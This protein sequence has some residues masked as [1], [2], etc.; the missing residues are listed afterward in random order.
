ML[1]SA[2]DSR[3]VRHVSTRYFFADPVRL[4]AMACAVLLMAMDRIPLWLTV[5][6]IAVSQANGIAMLVGI[7]GHGWTRRHGRRGREAVFATNLASDWTNTSVCT[8][9]GAMLLLRHFGPP[10]IVLALGLLALGIGLLPDVRFCRVMLSSDPITASRVLSDGY[11]FRD[12][13]KLG[14][15]IALLILCTLSERSLAFIFLSMA[16]LQL[17]SV[18]ILVDK[19]LTEVEAGGTAVGFRSPAIRFFLARDGQRVLI[20]LLPFFFVPLRLVVSPVEARWIAGA[21]AALIVIPDLFRFLTRET[22]PAPRPAKA[23]ATTGP[24]LR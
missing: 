17:N 8:L 7:I 6:T 5:A 2:P 9:V 22:E 20:M 23:F 15:L 19:Y 11:F 12:P 18:L 10:E 1:K 24:G 4:V 16:L 3:P 21:V 13:V 14:G